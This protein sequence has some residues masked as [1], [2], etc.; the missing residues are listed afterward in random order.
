MR[1]PNFLIIVV[2][3]LAASVLFPP[4]AA[5][6]DLFVDCTGSISGV[7]TSLQ[8]AIDSLDLVGPHTIYL[9]GGPCVENIWISDRQRLTITA[10]G[11][12]VFID[13]A[14]GQGG[15][16]M[17]IGNS[18]GIRLVQIGFINGNVGL[19]IDRASEVTLE[20]CTVGGGN[21][22][23]IGVYENSSLYLA[24]SLVTDNSRNGIAVDNSTILIDAGNTIQNNGRNGLVFWAAHGGIWGYTGAPVVFQGNA[25]GVT[26][27]NGSALEAYGPVNIQ[28]NTIGMQVLN[29]ASLVMFGD[30]DNPISITGNSWLGINTDGGFVQLSGGIHV[31]NNGFGMQP[32]HA[33]VRVDDNTFLYASDAEISGN[34]GPGIDAMNAGV[35]DLAASVVSNN[36]GDGIHLIGNSSVLFYPPNDNVVSGNGGLAVKCDGSSVFSGDHGGV[37]PVACKFSPINTSNVRSIKSRMAPADDERPP[38][39]IRR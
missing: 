39:R 18:T 36:R 10:E 4:R 28:N 19:A 32:L 6:T 23:G 34:Y 27:N 13:S 25:N 5:A 30:A 12:G 29:G 3:F 24:S 35:I 33:G 7:G 22:G 17:Y 37:A 2:L 26:L 1:K 31:T 21:R 9:L 11:I 20:G 14:A 38:K 16:A 8:A 15:T